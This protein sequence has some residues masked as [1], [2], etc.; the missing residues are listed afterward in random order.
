[1]TDTRMTRAEVRTVVDVVLDATAGLD[2]DSIALASA[3]ALGHGDYDTW[4]FLCVAL[5]LVQARHIYTTEH[6]D[7]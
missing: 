3:D 7:Q 1:M 2:R 5:R 6:G 4:A